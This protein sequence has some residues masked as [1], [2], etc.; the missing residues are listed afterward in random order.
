M[1]HPERPEL[2]A[3][4]IAGFGRSGPAST[5]HFARVTFLE[6]NRADL[7]RVG[8]RMLLVQSARAVLAPLAVGLYLPEQLAGSPLL[9]LNTLGYCPT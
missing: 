4:L 1:D 7:C 2:A 5:R 3:E 9:V 8:T 6:E